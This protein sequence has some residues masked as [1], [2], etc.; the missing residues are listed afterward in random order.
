[1]TTKK[2]ATKGDERR[3]K[4]GLL[5]LAEAMAKNGGLPKRSLEKVRALA[6]LRPN[7]KPR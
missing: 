6:E 4:A 1:M 3:M 2:T 5:E 7:K